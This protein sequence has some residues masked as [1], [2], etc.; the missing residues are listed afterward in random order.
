[1]HKTLVLQRRIIA[2]QFKIHASFESTFP[3]EFF[4]F[5]SKYQ[6]GPGC[7]KY[8]IPKTQ[9]LP[10]LDH[11]IVNIKTKKKKHASLYLQL[12]FFFKLGGEG[13]VSR[14]ALYK[15]SPKTGRVIG[16]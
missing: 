15:H 11:K 10:L 8:L 7:K 9:H 5:H 16:S 2:Q 14:A 1:M 12:N 6:T 4:Y 3:S 13:M